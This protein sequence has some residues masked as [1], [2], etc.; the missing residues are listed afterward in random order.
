MANRFKKAAEAREA[1]AEMPASVTVAVPEVSTPKAEP[2]KTAEI[3]AP[4]E[5]PAKAKAS[6]P[7]ANVVETVG[8]SLKVPKKMH[9][10]MKYHYAMT[11]EKM[12]AY[13]IRLVEEDMGKKF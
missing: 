3:P 8:M 9:E 1:R 5:K 7:A 11:G 10:A 2:S 13:I 6:I 12:T 4:A